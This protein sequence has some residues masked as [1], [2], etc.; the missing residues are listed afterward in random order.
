MSDERD[1]EAGDGAD[2]Y[3]EAMAALDEGRHADAL[4]C[5]SVLDADEPVRWLG[6]AEVWRDLGELARAENVLRRA[7]ELAGPDD[8]DVIWLDGS[9]KLARWDVAG[10]KAAFARLDAASEGAALYDGLALIADLEGDLKHGDRLLA[11]CRRLQQRARAPRLSPERFEAVVH[12]AAERLPEAFRRAFEEIAVVIDPMPTA[13]VVDARTTGHP[14]DVL[15][16]YV[17][18]ALAERPLAAPGEMPPT[19]FLFQRNLERSAED[20]DELREEIR[21]TLYHE[22]GHA[23]GFDEEGVAEM[24]LD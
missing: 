3:A 8:P 7:R 11:E 23:L 4:A 9:L 17:G 21:V 5:L 24:G 16:L 12:A 19:I 1:D 2:P 10:A 22:L 14:P 18:P 13:E 6:E 20:L 15:G